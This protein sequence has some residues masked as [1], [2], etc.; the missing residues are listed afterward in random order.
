MQLG[1][2]AAYARG[3]NRRQQCGCE[4]RLPGSCLCSPA[5]SMML[6]SCDALPVTPSGCTRIYACTRNRHQPPVLTV[7][8]RH[9]PSLCPCRSRPA[10]PH[11]PRAVDHSQAQAAYQLGREVSN[12]LWDPRVCHSCRWGSLCMAS[13]ACTR[14]QHA[15]HACIRESQPA[16]HAHQCPSVSIGVVMHSPTRSLIPGSPTLQLT[17]SLTHY[18]DPFFPALRSACCV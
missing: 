10:C 12:G 8:R 18:S 14:C 16:S 3:Q 5:C 4:A 2:L 7:L 6:Q 13:S 11:Q 15:H 1:I 9:P 17:H